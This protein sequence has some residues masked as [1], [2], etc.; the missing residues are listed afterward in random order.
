MA[1]G[2]TQDQKCQHQPKI[3]AK[4]SNNLRK[5]IIKHSNLLELILIGNR[6]SICRTRT[7]EYCIH[8]LPIGE[9]LNAFIRVFRFQL[10]AYFL[11]V[12]P[13]QQLN[14]LSYRLYKFYCAWGREYFSFQF[15][16][17]CNS[18]RGISQLILVCK[19]KCLR[20]DTWQGRWHSKKEKTSNKVPIK[21]TYYLKATQAKNMF[22]TYFSADKLSIRHL[23]TKRQRCLGTAC[24][25][26]TNTC[27][28]FAIVLAVDSLSAFSSCALNKKRSLK[29]RH[30]IFHMQMV[31]KS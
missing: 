10:Y 18:L 16:S 29:M 31:E 14:L 30:R 22:Y 21:L 25:A 19:T 20:L 3:P 8:S 2:V 6:F 17:N 23:N 11:A 4:E 13:H 7:F 9:L 28:I 26:S 27:K 15:R 12:K 5:V 24:R 1:L